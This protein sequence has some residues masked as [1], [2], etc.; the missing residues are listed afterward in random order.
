MINLIVGP[1]HSGT[2]FV[3]KLLIEH[4]ADPGEYDASTNPQI[5]YVKYENTELKTYVV[6]LLGIK[7]DIPILPEVDYEA[8]FK[9]YLSGLS[10]QKTYV[11]KYPRALFVLPHLRELIGPRLR[12]IYVNRGVEAWLDSHMRRS[13]GSKQELLLALNQHVTQLMLYPGPVL[14]VNF[15]ELLE[16]KGVDVL[17][18]FTGLK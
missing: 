12:V 4:G 5:D 7:T 13:G 9:K 14:K 6:S 2:S 11:L 16:G 1:A 10:P 3:T 17:C 15:E 8:R 18:C